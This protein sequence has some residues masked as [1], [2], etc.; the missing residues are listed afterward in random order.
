[1]K[2]KKKNGIFYTPSLLADHLVKPFVGSPNKSI[3]DPA[4]G[5][6]A[7]LLSAERIMK[8]SNNNSSAIN[9]FGCDIK[10]V[11]GLLQHL[12]E[13]NLQKLDFFDYPTS[14]K[15]NIILTNPP[16]VRHHYQ[17]NKKISVYRENIEGLDILNNK[18]DLWAFFLVKCAA[19]LE[20]GGSMGAIL[21]WA[22]LQADYAQ[23]LRKW[24]AENF[25]EIR[26]LALTQKY[27]KDAE[28]RVVLI[29]MR[30]YNT[31]CSKISVGFSKELSDNIVYKEISS[32]KWLVNKVHVNAE[33]T[34]DEILNKIKAIGFSKISNFCTVR[35]GVVTGAVKYFILSKSEAKMNGFSR[36]DMLP[37]VSSVKELNTY[38][39]RGTNLLKRLVLFK[40]SNKKIKN[41]LALGIIRK[42]DK[43]RHSE[44][45]EPWYAVKIGDIPDAFFPYRVS[46]L[47]FLAPNTF[48]I[49]STNSIHRVYFKNLTQT[50]KKWLT[51][52]L[53]SSYSQ[54]SIENNSKTYGRGMLKIEPSGF[55]DI[56]VLTRNDRSIDKIYNQFQL[57]IAN[58]NRDAAMTLA[59]KFIDEKLQI[60]REFSKSVLCDLEKL[61]ATRFI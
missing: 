13:A 45:R 29:W 3:L 2:S 15:H 49:Q 34:T 55:N 56:L 58:N 26:V 40:S 32:S 23:P 42:I 10:P 1:M 50:Q 17:D 8:S 27:F 41:Y 59:T 31:K 21:P 57:L 14:K 37:I 44:L 20:I 39:R 12:P 54:L 38:L 4:Y 16:Y 5:D 9:L 61:Q 33:L 48:N 35:I 18:A 11:N 46:K 30:N 7:L 19:H 43:R 60:D 28:E 36:K 25:K 52:S 51:L 6:G 22:F 24:L 47:P 53:S